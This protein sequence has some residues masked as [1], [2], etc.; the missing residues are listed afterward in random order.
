MDKAWPK[1]ADAVMG[2]VLGPQLGDLASLMSRD[3]RAN[4]QGSAYNS[5]WYGYVDKDLRTLAGRPVA[6]R[7]KTRFCGDGRP[8]HVPRL[9]VGG[10][11]P[12]RRWSSRTSSANPNP[13]DLAGGRHGREDLL[14]AGLPADHD[15][16]DQ[17]AHVPAG[18]QLLEPPLGLAYE[19]RASGPGASARAAPPRRGL[20]RLCSRLGDEHALAGETALPGV[21]TSPSGPPSSTSIWPSCQIERA[22]SRTTP[23]QIASS[24][25]LR[26]QA[27]PVVAAEW[28]RSA[29]LAGNSRSLHGAGL[30]LRARRCCGR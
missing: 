16:L 27:P 17:P 21:S 23:G 6:G 22:P 15:A 25:V 26:L 13:D 7:F 3:N 29:P 24:V 4:N 5:G 10:A 30:R 28:R 20:R 12:G 9:A 1:I 14:L 8:G 11:R 2:P 18:D 19:R